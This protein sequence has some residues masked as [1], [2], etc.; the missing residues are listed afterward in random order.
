MQPVASPQT[1]ASAEVGDT[2]ARILDATFRRLATQGYAALRV[3]DI[4]EEAGVNVALINYHFGSKDQLVIEVLDAANAR[5]LARQ[6]AMFEQPT[7]AAQKWSQASRFYDDDLAS[8]FVRVQTEL[9][10]ASMANADL[11]AKVTPRVVAWRGLIEKSVRETLNSYAAEGGHLPP[12]ITVEAL[13]TWIGHF[14][15]GLELIDLVGGA[16]ERARGRHALQAMQSLIES[17]DA[18]AGTRSGNAKARRRKKP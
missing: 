3:R 15:I 11:R 10:A 6:A 14:W 5:L 2:K 9:L 12:F 7:S 18:S 1:A 13:G 16:S 17:L 4:A 8:G